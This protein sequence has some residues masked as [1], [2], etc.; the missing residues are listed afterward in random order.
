MQKKLNSMVLGPVIEWKSARKKLCDSPLLQKSIL[1]AQT[2]ENVMNER[3]RSSGKRFL[4]IDIASANNFLFI[5]D[6]ALDGK[7]LDVAQTLY[8]H[9]L[10]VYIGSAYQAMRDRAMTGLNAIE[11][12]RKK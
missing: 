11:I 10:E 4:D 1:G 8:R 7:C 2:V 12:R 9:V 6:S 3:S 5:A